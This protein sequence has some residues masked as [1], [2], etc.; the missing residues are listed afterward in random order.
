MSNLIALAKPIADQPAAGLLQVR[1]PFDDTLLADVEQAG[2]SHVEAALAIANSLYAERSNWLPRHQRISILEKTA[3]LMKRDFDQLVTIAASEGGK[4]HPDTVVEVKRAIESVQLAAASAAH[5]EGEVIPL[6]NSPMTSGRLAFT[7]L[8]PI[9]PVVAV[10]AFNHPLNLIA[11]QIA[12]AIAAGCPVIVKPAE[13]TPLSCFALVERLLEAGLPAQWCIPLTTDTLDSATALVTDSR[14]AFFS[15]IGS[16]RVG[17]ML[18]NKLA[19]G[20]RCA[21]EHGGAAPVIMCE[22]ADFD[23]AL[24]ALLRGGFYHAGQVCVSVQRV[25]APTAKAKA[26]AMAIAAGA[27]QLKVGNPLDPTT[28]V[29]PLIRQA[30]VD[31]VQ[32]WVSEAIEEGAELLCGGTPLDNHSY[33]AT[34][35]LNPS[36][37]SK[38]SQLEIFGPV[39]CVYG[40][41]ELDRA[42]NQ[43]NSLPFSFQA[44]VFTSDI[45]Q[46]LMIS[47]ALRG[48]AIM[49]NDH[50]AFRHDGMPFAGLDQSGYGVGGIPYSLHEMQVRKMTVIKSPAL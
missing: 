26:L 21:L 30:E 12:P 23:S 37:D 32:Q 8:E 46:A 35:L 50:S 7:Q 19:A 45:D 1:S 33:A 47:K 25:F 17:W 42:I 27:R 36:P 15:F 18:R 39:V 14:V 29:G 28:E 13:D 3:E 10:S 34:V 6:N 4:P 22:D 49:I 40:Y 9:G 44:S 43:A 11:H 38:V 41:S 31:R 48:S 24:P 2:A 5:D 20:T 16:S